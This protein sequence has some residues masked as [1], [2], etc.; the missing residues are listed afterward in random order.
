MDEDS[1]DNEAL[2]ILLGAGSR[3][4]LYLLLALVVA[5]AID[6]RR[7]SLGTSAPVLGAGAAVLGMMSSHASFG[8]EAGFAQIVV[9]VMLG[10]LVAWSSAPR[11][12]LGAFFRRAW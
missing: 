4:V 1:I 3:W 8:P 10:V 9:A 5:M 12:E 11:R 2:D 7:P 6:R